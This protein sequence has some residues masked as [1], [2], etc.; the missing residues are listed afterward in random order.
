MGLFDSVSDFVVGK[1]QDVA[2]SVVKAIPLPGSVKRLGNKIANSKA[3]RFG[4]KVAG[5]MVKYGHKADS[6]GK[7]ITQGA[8]AVSK[9]TSKL[10][11]VT[12]GIPVIGAGAGL[13]N[14][15]VM[16]ASALGGGL[17]AVGSGVA[18][19]GKSAQGVIR[20]GRSL[21]EMRT[22]ADLISGMRDVA[23]ASNEMGGSTRNLVSQARSVGTKLQRRK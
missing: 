5:S 14:K 9:Y 19:M 21:G 11:S 12:G 22:G 17:S 16:G 4:E 8:D 6:L 23:R 3:L 7:K 1:A 2:G 13:I 10:A 18:G 20:V 15:G